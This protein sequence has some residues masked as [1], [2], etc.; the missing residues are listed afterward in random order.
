MMQLLTL[1]ATISV[2]I[3]LLYVIIFIA[4]ITK[5]TAVT[6]DQNSVVTSTVSDPQQQKIKAQ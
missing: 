1:L 4:D 2:G 3:S 5:S 6:A